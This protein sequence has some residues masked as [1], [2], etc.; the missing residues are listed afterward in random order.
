M[1]VSTLHVVVSFILSPF[2]LLSGCQSLRET[3]MMRQ[4]KIKQQMIQKI[5]RSKQISPNYLWAEEEVHKLVNQYRVSLELNPLVLNA[6]ISEVARKH[7]KDMAN[8]IVPIGHQGFRERIQQIRT[9]FS[10]AYSAEN[11]AWNFSSIEPCYTA[12]RGWINS[13]G[14]QKNMVGSFSLTGIGVELGNNGSYY[15]TQIFIQLP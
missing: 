3:Q 1:K 2:I 8:G 12:F 15:F 7:S 6:G 13:P 9:T 10:I 11:V 14:H 4:K 5:S